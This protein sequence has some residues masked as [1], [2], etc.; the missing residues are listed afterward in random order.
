MQSI[1]FD[2]GRTESARAMNFFLWGRGMI[3]FNAAK[4]ERR[5]FR[6]FGD[7]FWHSGLLENHQSRTAEKVLK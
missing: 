5:S 2:Y 1:E 3:I 6:R 4:F 7:N